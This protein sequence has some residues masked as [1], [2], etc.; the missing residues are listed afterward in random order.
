M[1]VAKNTKLIPSF[2]VMT[3]MTGCGT[4]EFSGGS[5]PSKETPPSVSVPTAPSESDATVDQGSY[6]LTQWSWACKDKPNDYPAAMPGATA[7]M[8]DAGPHQMETSAIP[9]DAKLRVSSRLCQAQAPKRDLVL[10]VDVSASMSS[11]W[12]VKTG[13][14]PILNGSCGRLNALNA[15]VKQAEESK[16]ARFAVITFSSAVVTS[17]STFFETAAALQTDLVSR[18]GGKSL[19]E[20]VCGGVAS[21][22]YDE[23]LKASADLFNASARKDAVRELYFISDGV[24]DAGREGRVVAAE[25]RKNT[26]IATVMLGS[27]DDK[28]LKGDIASKDSNQAPIHARASESKDL[29]NVVSG[30]SQNRIVGGWYGIRAAGSDVEFSRVNLSLDQLKSDTIL[31][32]IE[33]NPVNYPSGLEMR[34]EYWDRFNRKYTNTGALVWQ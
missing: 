29:S 18:S 3:L 7:S 6:G 13:N 16:A 34:F 1:K 25:I 15:L 10:T 4:T 31:P 8:K 33:L 20:I 11:G 14:D 17:S 23:G 9:A 26:T 24:P 19:A 32:D 22:S 12:L 28:I 30:L 2:V 5:A 21:T 27:E